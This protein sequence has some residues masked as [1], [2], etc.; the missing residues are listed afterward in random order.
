[1]VLSRV[2]MLREANAK[3]LMV[4]GASVSRS[5]AGTGSAKAVG[6]ETVKSHLS[7]TASVHAHY[8]SLIRETR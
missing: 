2:D 5:K 3:A 8:Y 6:R 7:E 1:V 4:M